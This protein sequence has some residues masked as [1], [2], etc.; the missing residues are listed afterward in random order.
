MASPVSLCLSV[1]KLPSSFKD[2]GYWV[3]S[4]PNPVPPHLHVM[5]SAKTL[6]P[7]QVN[8][9]GMGGAGDGGRLGL[10]CI[11]LV[12]TIQPTIPPQI[13]LGKQPLSHTART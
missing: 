3:R 8:F 13:T 1:F 2:T 12:D 6:F 7:N 9:T 5:T 4:H 11:F 10:Q